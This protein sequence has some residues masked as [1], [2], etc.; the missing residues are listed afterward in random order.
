MTAQAIRISRLPAVSGVGLVMIAACLWGTVGVA[1]ALAPSTGAIPEEVLA[2]ARTAI[3]GPVLVILS[4]AGNRDGMRRPVSFGIST[5]GVFGLSAAVFQLC[6]FHCFSVLGVTVTVF[7][8]VA[9]PPVLSALWSTARGESRLS[10]LSALALLM[11]I[12]GLVLFSTH[13]FTASP[14]D[15][16][17][18]ILAVIA[19]CAFVVM[20]QAARS[21]AQRGPP[22]LASGYGLMIS[23]I[24]L[25]PVMLVSTPDTAAVAQAALSSTGTLS[26]LLY[27]G[28]GPTALA[29][30]CYGEGMAR[31]TST[32][33]GL[34]ASM[35]EPAFAAVLA[36]I[37]LHERLSVLE[38]VGCI[39][40]VAA[41][42][43]L[44]HAERKNSVASY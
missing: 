37:M 10:T 20:S 21:L 41:M 14:L 15:G 6:L 8:T 9:L 44:W 28:L 43:I 19:S 24:V 26:L 40:L 23:A 5:L 12:A 36:V 25:L 31:C 11:A 30:V 4:F 33:T 35:V 34:I 7:L 29:Y 17:G 18:I 16:G 1:T 39:L 42:G 32:M 3:A 13:R 2:F 27:L 38:T 22:M